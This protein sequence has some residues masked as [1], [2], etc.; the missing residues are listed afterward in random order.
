MTTSRKNFL[1]HTAAIISGSLLYSK[2]IFAG[3]EVNQKKTLPNN[4]HPKQCTWNLKTDYLY[5]EQQIGMTYFDYSKPTPLSIDVM[6]AAEHG[7]LDENGNPEDCGETFFDACASTDIF[8]ENNLR[9]KV[10]Y[11]LNTA[12]NYTTTPLP[13]VVLFHAGAY[14]E[15]SQLELALMKTFCMEF[16]RKGFVAIT[17]EYR[18]GILKD[19]NPYTTTQ[20]ELALYRGQQDGRGAIRSIMKRNQSGYHDGLFR[21]NEDQFFVG[22]ASA[23]SVIALGC[24]Y[25]R[26]EAMINAVFL[27]KAGKP[28]IKDALGPLQADYYFGEIPD[29]THPY[30]P[31]IA[32]V[33]NCWGGIFIPKALDTHE[34]DF[35]ASSN[36][37]D[38]PP[39][40]S[41]QGELDDVFPYKDNVQQDVY[42]STTV[43]VPPHYEKE[44]SCLLITPQYFFDR[45]TISQAQVKVKVGSTLNM[46]CIL[47]HLNKYTEHYADSTMGH[48]LDPTSDFGIDTTTYDVQLYLVHRAATFFQAIMNGVSAFGT[49][50]R[51]YFRDCENFRVK[52]N[53]AE[54]NECSGPD[55]CQ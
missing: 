1:R 7:I 19:V 22:G 26:D 30:W 11:P 37:D 24:A 49:T 6:Y 5:T 14:A 15:C 16:A 44:N 40:I 52:C 23:G 42:Y 20:Q 43:S 39:M 3:F 13:V 4:F 45:S 21:F 35:F 10:Y 55:I 31:K 53:A 46:Y 9:Y 48:G 51:S 2:N 25:F 17:C 29:D 32:G 50:G 18:R 8:S 54:S 28:T 34:Y 12:H 38:N 27:S 41:F 33:F 36:P 47:Q